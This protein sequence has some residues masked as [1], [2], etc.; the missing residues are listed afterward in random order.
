[1]P[2]YNSRIVAQPVFEPGAPALDTA[3]TQAP[4]TNTNAV[5]TLAAASNGTGCWRI[6]TVFWSYSAVPS[7]GP[8]SLVITWNDTNTTGSP[9]QTETYYITAGGLG[10]LPLLRFFPPGTA[11]T[12]TLLAGG[13]GIS[14]T[15][16]VSAEIAG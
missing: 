12:L 2:S 13:S 1:M 3:A 7:P 8:G 15:V 16:Y 5:C 6:N 11:V 10:F 4:A 14:G 9:L